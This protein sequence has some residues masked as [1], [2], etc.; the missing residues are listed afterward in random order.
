MYH[1][2]ISFWIYFLFL[3]VFG[4][5]DIVEITLLFWILRAYGNPNLFLNMIIKFWTLQ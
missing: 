3:M 2:V 5:W 1:D 4:R